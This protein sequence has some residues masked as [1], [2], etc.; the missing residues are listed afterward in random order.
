MG[1]DFL[2][3]WPAMDLRR[4]RKQ[5]LVRNA[6]EVLTQPELQVSVGKGYCFMNGQYL[7]RG[8]SD[9]VEQESKSKVFCSCQILE[10]RTL[11]LV[12]DNFY[13]SIFCFLWLLVLMTSL[14]CFPFADFITSSNSTHLWLS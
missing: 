11:G 7:A 10:H 6:L 12:E 14:S 9:V 1:K 8:S 4:L 5:E 2:S 13:N 3:A